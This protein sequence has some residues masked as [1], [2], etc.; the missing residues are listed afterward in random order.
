M[1]HIPSPPT[2]YFSLSPP[3]KRLLTAVQLNPPPALHP[4]LYPLL[5]QPIGLQPLVQLAAPAVHT[6]AGACH[7]QALREGSY[8]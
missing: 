8:T 3:P 6:F 4:A 5:L 1:A 7:L 2:A